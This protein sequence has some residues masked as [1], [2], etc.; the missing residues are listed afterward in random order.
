MNIYEHKWLNV[1]DALGKVRYDQKIDFF[2]H[3][4]LQHFEI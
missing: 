2:G 3:D 4:G 1:I